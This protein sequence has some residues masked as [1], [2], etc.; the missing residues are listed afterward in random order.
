VVNAF[1]RL[2]KI[3]ELSENRSHT[4]DK[5][6]SY[7]YPCLR[8]GV[9]GYSFRQLFVSLG[10]TMLLLKEAGSPLQTNSYFMFLRTSHLAIKRSVRPNPLLIVLLSF[11]LSH[12]PA[13]EVPT[14]NAPKSPT[15]KEQAIREGRASQVVVGDCGI[16][17][18]C[19]VGHM[20][21]ESSVIAAGTLYKIATRFGPDEDSV[22]TDYQFV[23]AGV[24]KG[25]IVPGTSLSIAIPGGNVRIGNATAETTVEGMPEV[26][27]GAKY[28]LFL[29]PSRF[30]E[31]GVYWLSRGTPSIYPISSDGQIRCNHEDKDWPLCGA[32]LDQLGNL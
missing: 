15:L 23:P 13:Q 9:R 30:G 29:S 19:D 31:K 14:I 2:F 17:P 12:L 28:V 8:V 16:L 24:L 5:Y 11:P 20:I 21:R 26:L 25:D 4:I 3:N 32:R 18:A 10:S 27:P 1:S 7:T 6:N 22:W